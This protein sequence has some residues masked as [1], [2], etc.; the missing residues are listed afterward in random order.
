MGVFRRNC[1]T[2]L[3][4]ARNYSVSRNVAQ[5]DEFQT[6]GTLR[7]SRVRASRVTYGNQAR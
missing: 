4:I 5:I 6:V 2:F 1:N 3:R 7:I